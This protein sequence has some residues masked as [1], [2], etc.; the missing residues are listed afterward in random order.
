V[1]VQRLTLTS[2]QLTGPAFPPAWLEPG[3]LTSL[4]ALFLSGNAALS[5]T[6]P[7]S[8]PWLNLQSL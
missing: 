4:T 5:G 7:P 1:Q 8:M 3:S 2:N 6:L